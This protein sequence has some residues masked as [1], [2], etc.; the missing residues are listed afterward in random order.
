MQAGTR[1]HVYDII[2]A[3]YRI[4]IMLDHDKRVPE[5]TEPPERIDQLLVILLVEAN[6]GFIKH[7]QH[8]HQVGPYLGCQA[9]PLRLAA[10]KGAGIS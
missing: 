6:G 7:I 5:V 1:P 4:L 9:D 8:P 2:G 10:R 3:P